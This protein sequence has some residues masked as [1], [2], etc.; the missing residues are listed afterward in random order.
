MTIIIYMNNKPNQ[1]DE[2]ATII[3]IIPISSTCFG[4]PFCPSS[5]ALD[6]GVTQ[7]PSYRTARHWVHYTTSC[8]TQS[9]APED[10]QNVELIGI[11]NTVVTVASSWLYLW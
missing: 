3:L 9:S 1:L 11:I 4:Q 7:I 2:T 6:C 10:G 8:I 5:G